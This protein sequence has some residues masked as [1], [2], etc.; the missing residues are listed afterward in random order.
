MRKGY[1]GVMEVVMEE[2]L[3]G[4]QASRK[5]DD[6][7]CRAKLPPRLSR[8]TKQCHPREYLVKDCLSAYCSEAPEPPN[9]Y[10]W[11]MLRACYFGL[12]CPSHS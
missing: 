3:K 7:P 11:L 4:E 10:L 8:I 2:I 1:K 6:S 5:S 12:H 9:L